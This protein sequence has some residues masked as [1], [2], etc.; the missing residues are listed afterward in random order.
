MISKETAKQQ[1]G[2]YGVYA[3][4]P[5]VHALAGWGGAPAHA[6]MPKDGL[7]YCGLARFLIPLRQDLPLNRE[8]GLWTTSSIHLL[9]SAPYSAKI[10]GAYEAMPAFLW[11]LVI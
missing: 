6:Q 3:C 11:V 5:H 10:A 7:G 4:V 2:V 9:V 1:C 8:L